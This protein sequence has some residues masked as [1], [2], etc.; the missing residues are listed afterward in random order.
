RPGAATARAALVA[1]LAEQGGA[2]EVARAGQRGPLARTGGARR[3]AGAGGAGRVRLGPHRDAARA[4]DPAARH[5]RAGGDRAVRGR[6]RAER[7]RPLRSRASPAA[8]LRFV[9]RGGTVHALPRGF[10]E[11]LTTKLLSAREKVALLGEPFRPAA[12]DGGT[13]AEFFAHRL[14]S[15]GRFLGDAIQTGIH[16]G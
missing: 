1:V 3:L 6:G 14:G 12:P 15:G 9:E 8:S 5:R 16:A 10:G 11:A 13:V 2:G 4:A 7:F